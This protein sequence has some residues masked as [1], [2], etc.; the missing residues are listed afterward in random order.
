MAYVYRFNFNDLEFGELAFSVSSST[1]GFETPA[2]I[3]KQYKAYRANEEKPSPKDFIG[4]LREEGYYIKELEIDYAI[5][6][7]LD[8]VD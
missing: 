2:E 5:E 6:W 7:D 4:F 3:E 1:L 8:E